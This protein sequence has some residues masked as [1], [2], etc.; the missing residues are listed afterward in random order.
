MAE[1]TWG[2]V[3]KWSGA[4]EQC[5][6]LRGACGTAAE[7]DGG[8]CEENRRGTSWGIR[9]VKQT[10]TVVSA[11]WAVSRCTARI[12]SPQGSPTGAQ[13]S[14]FTAGQTFPATALF[15]LTGSPTRPSHGTGTLYILFSW[16]SKFCWLTSRLP[17]WR[18]SFPKEPSARS[19]VDGHE[20]ECRSEPSP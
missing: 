7:S 17:P 18:Y 10:A 11:W 3:P 9:R 15:L 8:S 12:P 5:C 20:H 13:S 14:W 6:G 19:P 4:A 1:A 16:K 2:C